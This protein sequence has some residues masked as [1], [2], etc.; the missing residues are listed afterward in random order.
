MAVR[1]AEGEEDGEVDFV[2]ALEEDFAVLSDFVVVCTF[3]DEL[4]VAEEVLLGGTYSCSCKA[5]DSSC[6]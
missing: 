4:L 5:A 2:D 3:T 1:H 6:R